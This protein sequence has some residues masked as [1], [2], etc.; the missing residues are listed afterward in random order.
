MDHSESYR[1][2][3]TAAAVVELGATMRMFYTP[4]IGSP[5]VLFMVLLSSAREAYAV[6][7]AIAAHAERDNRA[8][9]LLAEVY[10][11]GTLLCDVSFVPARVSPDCGHYYSLNLV[12]DEMQLR[13]EVYGVTG[14]RSCLFGVTLKGS[15]RGSEFAL[16]NTSTKSLL[17]N[18][19]ED[20]VKKPNFFRDELPRLAC[21]A[22]PQQGEGGEETRALIDQAIELNVVI[23]LSGGSYGLVIK[24]NKATNHAEVCSAE[25]G[26]TLGVVGLGCLRRLIRAGVNRMKTSSPCCANGNLSCFLE[27]L[28]V[29]IQ[30]GNLSGS[31][32]PTPEV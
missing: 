26:N 9:G 10:L 22:G 28:P 24:K 11:A 14:G 32:E 25:T 20:D 31:P 5:D 13:T 6:T 21:Q 15:I 19:L 3:S 7:G 27:L 2:K 23:P 30:G 16:L 17:A 4:T 12:K 29:I 1:S 8:P 18:V